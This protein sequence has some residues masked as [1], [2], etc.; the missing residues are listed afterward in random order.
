MENGGASCHPSSISP[1][2]SITLEP[3]GESKASG[4]LL[5]PLC[6]GHM[7]SPLSITV[8]AFLPT[9]TSIILR[10]VPSPAARELRED[11]A[12]LHGPKGAAW[13]GLRRVPQLTGCLNPRRLQPGPR[14]TVG[15]AGGRQALWSRYKLSPE[16]EQGGC[17]LPALPLGFLPCR[18]SPLAPL[19]PEPAR[20]AKHSPNPSWGGG[21]LGAMVDTT[22]AGHDGGRWGL[23][24]TPT[25]ATHP[26]PSPPTPAPGLDS[27]LA[28]PKM[29]M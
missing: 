24:H 27:C 2:P 26:L 17:R 9:S 6:S 21:H 29:E 7:L 16:E 3:W 13:G 12:T 15:Q 20:D 25:L 22:P 18:S 8:H 14:R 19:H 23:G 1:Q 11:A 5:P 28:T 4:P 10:A